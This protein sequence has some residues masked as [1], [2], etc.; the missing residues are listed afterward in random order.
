MHRFSSGAGGRRGAGPGRAGEKGLAL[1]RTAS[2]SGFQRRAG[3]ADPAAPGRCRSPQ[4]SP[5]LLR[6]HP[7]AG[8]ST[9]TPASATPP[10]Q[11]PVSPPPR[12]PGRQTASTLTWYANF[13]APAARA[14]RRTAS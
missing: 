3:P 9:D 7:A 5:G 6:G 10:R 13:I 12:V 1:R 8:S 2:E 11:A 14:R 4:P